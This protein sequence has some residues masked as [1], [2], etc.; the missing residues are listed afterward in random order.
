MWLGRVEGPRLAVWLTEEMCVS[1]P[2]LTWGRTLDKPQG[3]RPP[4]QAGG[5][6][7]HWALGFGVPPLWEDVGCEVG[8]S[9]QDT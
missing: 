7:A 3:R 4:H 2:R 6:E 5:H 9:L 8:A 1:S